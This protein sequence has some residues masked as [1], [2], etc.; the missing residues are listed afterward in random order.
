[1]VPLL[2]APNEW[3][4]HLHLVFHT[5][6]T[7][8]ISFFSRD[9]TTCVQQPEAVNLLNCSLPIRHWLE[10]LGQ[11]HDDHAPEKGVCTHLQIS[12]TTLRDKKK[13]RSDYTLPTYPM[14]Q[15]AGKKNKNFCNIRNWLEIL[16]TSKRVR[17]LSKQAPQK[18]PSICS[19][20]PC[21]FWF[22][23]GLRTWGLNRRHLV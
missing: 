4:S 9:E 1:M 11:C 23:L 21:E 16:S 12:C 15:S 5:L 3:L 8:E 14:S 18:H 20:V 7:G 22:A 2:C 6:R 13:H 10:T 17:Q 19:T